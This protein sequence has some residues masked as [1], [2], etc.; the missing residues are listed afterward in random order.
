MADDRYQ[1]SVSPGL[2]PKHAK[3]GIGIVKRHALYNARQYFRGRGL[4]LQFHS[5]QFIAV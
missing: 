5:I 1:V 3:A 2:N 4:G